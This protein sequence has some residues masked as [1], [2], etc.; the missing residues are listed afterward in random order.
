M[1]RTPLLRRT[2]LARGMAR[3]RR[4]PLAPVSCRRRAER[5]VRQAVV[6]EVMWR[7]GGRCRGIDLIGG[8]VCSGRLDAHEVIPR[9]AWPGGHLVTLNVVMVCRTLHD[10]IGDHPDLAHDLGLHGFSW[11][12]PS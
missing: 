9:S 4:T 1:K 12:R 5:A 2:P 3:L 6:D 10:W 8:H 7:D 11:E